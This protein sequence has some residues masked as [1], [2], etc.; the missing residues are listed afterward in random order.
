MLM[1]G[2]QVRESKQKK[3]IFLLHREGC[4]LFISQDNKLAYGSPDELWQTSPDII[5]VC[6]YPNGEVVMSRA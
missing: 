1:F 2:S 4:F 5:I 6:R 3:G